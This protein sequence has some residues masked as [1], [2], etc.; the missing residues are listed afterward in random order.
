M[1]GIEE[2]VGVA[3]IAVVSA[4]GVVKPSGVEGAH[5]GVVAVI[6]LG[7]VVGVGV[8]TAN[9]NALEVIIGGQSAVARIGGEGRGREGRGVVF[10]RHLAL[11]EGGGSGG[12]SGVRRRR[13]LGDTG[14]NG[15]GSVS[16]H[17]WV[18]FRTTSVFLFLILISTHTVSN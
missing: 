16:V 12:R 6:L 2:P 9:G 18:N 7:I 17:S 13:R 11:V 1:P 3:P 10:R 15:S 8:S 14:T 5:R 4:G